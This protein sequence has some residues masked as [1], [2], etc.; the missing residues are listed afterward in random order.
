MVKGTENM[1]N[2]KRFCS[3]KAR[4]AIFLSLE[5]KAKEAVLELE[6]ENISGINGVKNIIEKLDSLYK[7]DKVQVAYETYNTFEKFQRSSD[8][9][10]IS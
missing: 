9:W 8:V 7:K 2:I 10:R 6:I 4:S 1:A 5:G 3:W